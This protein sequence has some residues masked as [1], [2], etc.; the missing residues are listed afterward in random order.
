[1][2]RRR[3]YIP[4]WYQLSLLRLLIVVTLCGVVCALY[5][6]MRRPKDTHRPEMRILK[7]R[8]EPLHFRTTIGIDLG[9]GHSDI[10]WASYWP[11]DHHL[12]LEDAWV[13]VPGSK[14]VHFKRKDGNLSTPNDREIDADVEAKWA[15]VREAI[16][17]HPQ[18]KTIEVMDLPVITDARMNKLPEPK[19]VW[20][21]GLPIPGEYHPL[22]TPERAAQKMR[23]KFGESSHE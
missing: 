9:N 3:R 22:N 19:P 16:E 15:I 11:A 6:A 23:P 14:T 17:K 4:R 20:P 7:I 12:V 8:D 2:A 1:M 21:T 5:M 10:Y 18:W 13:E